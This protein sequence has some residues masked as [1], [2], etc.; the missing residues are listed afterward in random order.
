[1]MKK[2]VVFGVIFL[3]FNVQSFYGMFGGGKVKNKPTKGV[4]QVQRYPLKVLVNKTKED[5]EKRWEGLFNTT[6]TIAFQN[7]L[8]W[9]NDILKPLAYQGVWEDAANEQSL[10]AWERSFGKDGLVKKIT[11][12]LLLE[13]LTFF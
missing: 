11:E 5:I 6:P 8:V 12:S 2:Y 7:R 4:A 9:R 10:E 13:G 3:L 1:M